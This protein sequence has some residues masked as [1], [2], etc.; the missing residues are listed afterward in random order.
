VLDL[1]ILGVHRNTN[2]LQSEERMAISKHRKVH[3][4]RVAARYVELVEA[5]LASGL[6]RKGESGPS[7]KGPKPRPS[8]PRRAQKNEW[9]KLYGSARQIRKALR[10]KEIVWN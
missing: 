1:C 5:R 6:N 2:P 8:N 9:I 4:E 3:T 10:R 7:P